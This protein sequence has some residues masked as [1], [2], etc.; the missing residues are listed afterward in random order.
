MNREERRTGH[1]TR[2]DVDRALLPFAPLVYVAWADGMLSDEEIGHIGAQVAATEGVDEATRGVLARW[3]DPASPPSSSDLHGLLALM[4]RVGATLPEQDRRTLASLGLAL[5]RTEGGG[6]PG[7]GVS[8][9]LTDMEAALGVAS[10][11]ALREIVAPSAG[12]GAAPPPPFSPAEL[13]RLLDGDQHE[14][15]M[16]VLG[17]LSQRQFRREVEM[18]RGEYRERVLAWCRELAAHGL[19]GV[20]YPQRYGGE[21]DVVKQIAIFETLAFHDLS[22]V[23]KYG[24]QFGLFGGAILQL[25]TRP[26]HERWL[27]DASTLAL[28]GCFAMTETAH[29]SNVRDLETVASYDAERGDFV[30]RTPRPEAQKDY[31]GNA[32]E[33]GRVAIVFA[34]LETGGERHGVHAFFVPLREM[35]G[36]A[37]PGVRIEDCGAKAGLNGV[38]NGRLVFHDVRIP[39]DHLLDRFGSVAADGTYSSP[40]PSASRRFFTMLAT[41]VAGRIS[42]ACASNSV[43]KTALTIAVRYTDQRRQFG[44]SG[45]PEVPLLDYTA[46]QRRLLP[47]LATTYALHFALRDL[48]RRYAA[49]AQTEDQELEVL[50]A[51]L[52]AH[53]SDHAVATLRHAREACGGQ[54]YLS[55]N[56]FGALK[57]DADV[58]TTFEGANAVLRQL[59]AKGLLTDYRDQ[60]GEIRVLGIVKHLTRRAA[61][62]VA[63]LNPIATRRTEESH[64]R[65]PDFQL[66]ALRYRETRLLGSAARRLKRRIDDGVDS[67]DALNETQ[68][69]LLQ[70]ARAFA[71][72]VIA[73]RFSEA[74]QSLPASPIGDAL[75]KLAALHALSIMEEDR[76]WFLEAGYFEAAKSR[77]V[78]AQVGALCRELRDL[79][80]PLVDAFG[81]PDAVLGAPIALSRASDRSESAAPS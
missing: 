74:V 12:A 5:A 1:A 7:S 68:D 3:L 70:L 47:A 14:A 16:R 15:R 23:V 69:H 20:A 10:A 44:P 24:V 60:F 78:R 54:G 63:E 40:I 58:F 51:A 64:L 37:C 6:E 8:R 4:R 29:G 55:E 43:A 72:R 19:G 22:L 65:D 75:R 77:A 34:Q 41:L 13:Q 59:V 66:A 52:K 79:A 17:L 49:Q 30:I 48:V 11:E 31:I 38:D 36:R 76:A 81:I 26:H 67:F 73:E 56:R 50:A 62:A 39:R 57:A 25:G 2:A 32:A 33:H 61:T 42:I 71:D 46:M 53:A 27:R 80:V 21:G 18:S 45:S 28:P 35:D 9:A